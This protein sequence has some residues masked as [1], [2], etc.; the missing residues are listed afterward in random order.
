M[1]AAPPEARARVAVFAKAPV[2]GLVKTRLATLLGADG[3]AALHA[4]LVRRALSTAVE[5][6]LGPVELWC[7]PDATHSFF[8]RCAELFGATLH[9]QEGDDLGSRMA[10]AFEHGLAA[11]DRVVLIG[12]DCP[13]LKPSDLRDAAAA[14]ATHDVAFAPAED[15]G[16]VLVALSRKLPAL[17]EGVSWGTSAV[18]GQTRTR[19]AELGVR[20]KELPM[21]WDVDRPEDFARLQLEGRLPEVLS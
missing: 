13:V 2:P 18:M 9:V 4:G 6:R 21:R 20:C 14:V 12:S 1:T 7:A 3:A 16:Y 15:G 19:V 5:S 11:G 8:S 17:F 10:A